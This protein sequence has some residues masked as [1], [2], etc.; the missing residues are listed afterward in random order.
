MAPFR[1]R[2]AD[3]AAVAV[4]EAF[5]RVASELWTAQRALLAS[6]PTSRD[7]GSPLREALDAFGVSLNRVD[8]LMNG[9]RFSQTER[10][11]ERCRRALDESR[12][13]AEAL[14]AED[15]SLGFE[16]LNARLGDVI[17]PLEEFADAGEELRRLTKR[18]SRGK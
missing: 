7:P 2:D 3:P 9:W 5:R 8:S 16:A 15:P 10:A 14:R 1:R 6:V 4:G 17:A 13:K 11:W 12:Q 18:R